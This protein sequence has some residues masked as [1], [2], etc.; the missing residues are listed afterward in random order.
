MYY[1]VNSSDA[2]VGGTAMTQPLGKCPGC[3]GDEPFEQVHAS[4]QCPDNG[5]ECTEW[6]CSTCGAGVFMGTVIIGTHA[7]IPPA[8]Q[9]FRAA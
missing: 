5:G 9:S 6:A 8:T 2:I 7:T 3:G 1:A 4:H